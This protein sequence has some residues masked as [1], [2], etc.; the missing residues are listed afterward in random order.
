MIDTLT[1]TL[2]LTHDCTLRCSYCYAGRKYRHAMARETAFRAIDLAVEE[3][4][5]RGGALDVNFFGG[6][7]LLEWDLL[8]A[9]DAYAREKTQGLAAP[10]RNSLTTNG[11]LLTPDKAD[12]MQ[13]RDYLLVLS[14]DGHAAMHNRNRRYADGSGSHEAVSAALEELN[15]R[16]NLRSHLVCVVTPNNVHMLAEGVA[17]LHRHYNGDFG[18]NLDY[19]S[20]WSDEQFAVLEEQYRACGELALQCYREGRPL[21]MT[22]LDDK[23]RSHLNGGYRDCDRCCIG[24]REIC[25]SVDGNFFPCSRLVGDGDDPAITFGNVREGINRAR[26]EW[27]IAT[28]GNRN[29]QCLGCLLRPRCHNGCGCTNYASTGALDRI[30]PLICASEQLFISVADDVAGQLYTERNAGFLRRFY[31]TAVAVAHTRI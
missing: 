2:C 12:W 19:W 16:P 13:E 5:R 22:N 21:L 8:K 17:W 6:E 30:S 15:R 11:T 7:P 25:V 10:M 9:C 31:G 1:L 4:R 3:A 26:Q 20:R 18:L 28:R 23:I 14:V 29:P 24:E 27:L